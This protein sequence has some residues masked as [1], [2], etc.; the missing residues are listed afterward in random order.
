MTNA[1]FVELDDAKLT[2]DQLFKIGAKFAL[3]KWIDELRHTS[4]L[5][6]HDGVKRVM[7]EIAAAM[8]ADRDELTVE[9]TRSAVKSGSGLM[10]SLREAHAD[11]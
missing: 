2:R 3:D 6:T 4:A 1:A 8:Q 10:T 7:V 9:L 11:V 5:Q